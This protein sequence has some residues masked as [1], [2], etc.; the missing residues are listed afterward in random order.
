VQLYFI[1]YADKRFL[2]NLNLAKIR[3]ETMELK[4][5]YSENHLKKESN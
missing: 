5:E 4:R 1:L 2:D 3:I